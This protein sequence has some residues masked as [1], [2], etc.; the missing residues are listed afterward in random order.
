MQFGWKSKLFFG[1]VVVGMVFRACGVTPEEQE[2]AQAR[3]RAA[4]LAAMSPA[5]RA[6]HE[7]AT[8]RA[9]LAT[10][11]AEARAKKVA[12]EQMQQAIAST[13][14]NVRD[15]LSALKATPASKR[16][17]ADFASVVE[18]LKKMPASPEYD[19][20]LGTYREL[21][22]PL[23]NRWAKDAADASVKLLAKE[24]AEKMD[25]ALLESG[26]NIEVS[27]RKAGSGY[28]AKIDYALMSRAL[29][30]KLANDGGM[31]ASAKV[32]GINRLVFANT[33]T[34]DTWTYE[35]GGEIVLRKEML[36]SVQA[37]WLLR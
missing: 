17:L 32:A 30:Y 23:A 14:Q 6:A 35:V 12:D 10:K 26:S 28:F 22:A 24:W 25:Q 29:A 20:L 3:E 37:T 36:K 27:V 5:E 2:A 1:M 31:F 16:K 7:L 8:R 13:T 34:D 15:G 33:I 11:E 9:L 21:V 19:S 4:A 18:S